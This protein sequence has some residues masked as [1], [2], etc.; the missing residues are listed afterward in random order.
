MIENDIANFAEPGREP[1]VR[2][3]LASVRHADS[4]KRPSRTVQPPDGPTTFRMNRLLYVQTIEDRLSL[5]RTNHLTDDRL[6]YD[7]AVL[8]DEP[9]TFQTV[10]ETSSWV[11][12]SV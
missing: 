1:S 3:A 12:E 6:P 7:Q 5:G 11:T 8:S 4:A 2:V 9:S 10:D